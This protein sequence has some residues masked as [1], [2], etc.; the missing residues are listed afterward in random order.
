MPTSSPRQT[1]I[2]ELAMLKWLI[3]RKLDAFQR[4]YGYDVSYMR[5][6]LDADLGAVLRVARLD[7]MANYRRD[8]PLD[9]Y[10]AAKLVGTVSEDC[11]PCTQLMVAMALRDGVPPRTIAAVLEGDAATHNGALDDG[12]RLCVRFARATLAHDPAAD[13]LRDE[14]ARRWGPR[15]VVSLAFGIAAAR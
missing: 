3:R 1:P 15:A 6:M 2:K 14:I 7:G 5:E 11:G 13:E 12:A 9:A 8:I 10:Y 4:T